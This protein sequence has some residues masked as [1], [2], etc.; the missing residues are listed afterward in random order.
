MSMTSELLSLGVLLILS[1]TVLSLVRFG[2][3]SRRAPEKEKVA[4]LRS[5]CTEISEEWGLSAREQQA[6]FCACMGMTADETANELG[7]AATTAKTHIRHV[8]EKLGVHS[9]A[10]L[11]EL[12]SAHAE[13]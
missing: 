11:I 7:I 1:V 2:T 3:D 9:R 10:E 12:V 5:A 4:S 6:M 13:K 8:Y